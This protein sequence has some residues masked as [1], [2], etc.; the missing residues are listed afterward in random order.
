V[1][2]SEVSLPTPV[3]L[4]RQWTQLIGRRVTVSP[5]PAPVMPFALATYVDDATVVVA[6][7][8]F[9]AA[10]AAGLG[11]ALI[12]IPPA[13]AVDA[14]KDLDFPDRLTSSFHEVANVTSSL[15]ARHGVHVKLRDTNFG[16][17]APAE[18]VAPVLSAPR[19]R[20]DLAVAVDGYGAGACSFLLA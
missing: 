12:L 8:L 15:F 5:G 13:V 7:G 4:A 11:A 17:P 19:H 20:A 3:E 9:D 1:S 6:A 10:L 16:A 18:D 2:A 14:A